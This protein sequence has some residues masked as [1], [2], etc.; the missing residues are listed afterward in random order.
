MWSGSFPAAGGGVAPAASSGAVS[1]IARRVGCMNVLE[2]RR[3]PTGRR[4]GRESAVTG[5]LY[6][7]PRLSDR[8][9]EPVRRDGEE[10]RE[11]HV[12]APGVPAAE[13]ERRQRQ[14]RA[15]REREH[16]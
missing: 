12:A 7:Q 11:D 3:S 15:R 4:G 2:E 5:R 9:S 10:D 6:Q 13:G 16:P 14:K 1:K 8:H